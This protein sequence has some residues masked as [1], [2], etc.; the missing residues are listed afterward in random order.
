MLVVDPDV[1]PLLADAGREVPLT[2]VVALEEIAPVVLAFDNTVEVEV[3]VDDGDSAE[4]ALTLI[5]AAL[6]LGAVDVSAD[7]DDAVADDALV[8]DVGVSSP[9]PADAPPPAPAPEDEPAELDATATG[10]VLIEL[11]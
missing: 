9:V 11:D 3:A 8:M 7:V 6:V 4:L 10:A 5:D 2:D 1:P